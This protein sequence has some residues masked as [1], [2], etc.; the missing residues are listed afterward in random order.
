MPRLFPLLSAAAVVLV[1]ALPAARADIVTFNNLVGP[2]AL[3]VNTYFEGA[4]TVTSSSGGWGEDHAFGNPVPS[5][6][7]PM[8]SSSIDV[9]RTGGGTFTFNSVDLGNGGTGSPNYQVYGFLNNA[10]IF[11]I[12]SSLP[13]ASGFYTVPTYDNTIQMDTLRITMSLNDTSSVNVDNINLGNSVPEPASLLLLATTLIP[14]L[15]RRRRA[16]TEPAA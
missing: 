6:F 3:V 15:L 4:F 8:P 7:S 16:K 2:Q 13:N 11:G 14:A 5:I 10:W 1:S 12:S 9:T